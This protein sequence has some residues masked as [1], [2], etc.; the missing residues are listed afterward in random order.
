MLARRPDL[1]KHM[2]RRAGQPTRAAGIR[3]N[4]NEQE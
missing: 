1:P 2:K 3:I 4:A